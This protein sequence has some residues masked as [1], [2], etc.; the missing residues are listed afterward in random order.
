V[1]EGFGICCLVGVGVSWVLGLWEL[2]VYTA[3]VL[4]SAYTFNKVLHYL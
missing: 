2:S 1:F 4:K 3:Y